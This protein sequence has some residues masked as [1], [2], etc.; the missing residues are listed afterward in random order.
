MDKIFRQPLMVGWLEK[1]K[2]S[3]GRRLSHLILNGN[4]CFS[5]EYSYTEMG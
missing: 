1:K 4:L 3:S 5:Q 2:S